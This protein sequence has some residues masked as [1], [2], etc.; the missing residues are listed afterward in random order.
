MAPVPQP[1]VSDSKYSTTEDVVSTADAANRMK[2][3]EPGQRFFNFVRVNKLSVYW[4]DDN[5]R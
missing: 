3:V 2:S 5:C 4:S 1:A